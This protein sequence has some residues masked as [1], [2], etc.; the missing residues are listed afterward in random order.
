M[1]PKSQI[2]RGVKNRPKLQRPSLSTSRLQVQT[3]RP[4]LEQARSVPQEL[5]EN[6]ICFSHLATVFRLHDKA[7]VELFFLSGNAELMQQVCGGVWAEEGLLLMACSF[8][9]AR[10]MMLLQTLLHSGCKAGS[11][12]RNY[13]PFHWPVIAG[14]IAQDLAAP[15]LDLGLAGREVS[16]GGQDYYL[17]PCHPP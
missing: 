16:L 7:I 10:L 9:C 2:Q 14:A 5:W 15:R 4:G 11:A 6:I 12:Q 13:L 17:P 8:T 3:Q 1:L